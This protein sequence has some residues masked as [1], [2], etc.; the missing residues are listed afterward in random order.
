[1]TSFGNRNSCVECGVVSKTG[2]PAERRDVMFSR[3]HVATRSGC[4][5]NIGLQLFRTF[6]VNLPR[7]DSSSIVLLWKRR[8]SRKISQTDST[9]LSLST[10]V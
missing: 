6:S 4:E 2:R 9:I 3:Q 7:L 8:R 1:M 5:V 10:L